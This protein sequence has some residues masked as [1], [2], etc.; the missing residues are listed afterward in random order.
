MWANVTGVFRPHTEVGK[1]PCVILENQ[2]HEKIE[3]LLA[4]SEHHIGRDPDWSDLK[5]PEFGWEIISRHHATLR[6][7]GDNYVIYD[8]DGRTGSTNKT[9]IDDVPVSVNEGV[10]LKDGD[11]LLI[12]K[13]PDR[14][15]K[16]TYARTASK[17]SYSRNG[18]PV[19]AE[20]S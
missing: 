1:Q 12:G 8:G 20:Q 19:K 16:M 9:F 13:D 17:R 5:I 10:T 18:S 11:V 15:V 2:S 6:R 7:E 14:Q 3:F 4:N